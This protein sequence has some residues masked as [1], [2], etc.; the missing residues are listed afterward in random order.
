[1]D[2][3]PV[4]AWSAGSFMPPADIRQPTHV[5]V[6]NWTCFQSLKAELSSLALISSWETLQLLDTGKSAQILD[7]LGKIPQIHSWTW[8]PFVYKA[9]KLLLEL[10]VFTYQS[11]K[12]C[13]LKV[14]QIS[15]KTWTES[16]A[17]RPRLALAAPIAQSRAPGIR[18]GLFSRHRNGF[19]VPTWCFSF[20][21]TLYA[22]GPVLPNQQWKSGNKKIRPP[23]RP[24]A[25]I[26]HCW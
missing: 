25:G 10:Q 21:E 18:S 17:W 5:T 7:K 23:S 16:R 26:V 11:E 13:K 24:D 19:L 1:M 22:H 14:G 2:C 8:N 4:Q 9:A 20:G 12:P 6:S 15:Q 3:W